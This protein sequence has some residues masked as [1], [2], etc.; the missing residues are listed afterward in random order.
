MALV[1]YRPGDYIHSISVLLFVRGFF[2]FPSRKKESFCFISILPESPRWLISKGHYEHAERVLRRIANTNGKQ[3]DQ[4]KFNRLVY[5][6][7]KVLRVD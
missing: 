5:E 3:F 2:V 7:K 6:E 1:E 4:T